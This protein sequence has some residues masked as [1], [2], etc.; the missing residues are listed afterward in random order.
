M[1]AYVKKHQ[2]TF[3]LVLL[4][5]VVCFGFMLTHH[6]I[7]IDEETWILSDSPSLL[8]L[9][10]GRF[11]TEIFNFFFTQQGRYA[12]FLW[13]F[14]S[15]VLWCFS[16]ILFSYSLVGNRKSCKE[17]PLFFFLA[18]FVS[19]PFVVGELLSFSM[20]NLQVCVAMVC[21]AFA[22]SDTLYYIE[23]PS[24]LRIVRILLLLIFSFSIYQCL[25][26]VYI[27][28]VVAF[29][30]LEFTE[31]RRML[32]RTVFISASFCM[33]SILLYYGG[34]TLLIH[35]VGADSYLSDNYVGWFSEGSIFKALFLAFAN[36]ARVSLAI[37]VLDVEI[38]GGL[39]IRI[40]TACFILYALWLFFQQKGIKDKALAFFYTLALV[41]A[42]FTLY[43][44]LGT[45]K[46]HGRILQALPLAG[47]VE[48]YI[49]LTLLKK[50]WFKKT[51]FV[52][53][54][55]LLFL[56]ARN[57]NMLFY[58]GSIAYEHDK[59]IAN[60]IMFEI[61]KAGFDYHEKPLV[62]L[63]S[64]PMDSI[65]IQT[66]ATIGASIFEWDDGN[67]KRM[68]DFLETEGYQ[69]IYPS[70][71]AVLEALSVMENMSPWPQ[72]GCLQET[73]NGIVIY[74]SEPSEKWYTVNNIER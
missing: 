6:T 36:I 2:K 66:S 4:F 19:M 74:L 16:G 61:Q 65:S 14:L 71:D 69:V 28:A 12:P 39:P 56:N 63:G 31:G 60:L 40:V 13:D 64:L 41:M 23:H 43:L 51:A 17:I 48:I 70:D 18:Y 15:I 57:M 53:L 29:C 68:T 9:F 24:A 26:N 30:L 55:Y 67:M 50:E 25:I 34:N 52:L 7:T 58:Y 21:V 1:A 11:G 32:G 8:W 22:F 54:A 35:L 33:L 44:V 46:T 3:I 62:F 45:Y 38:Y 42:P 5:A 27:T 72:E 49:I 10:Q 20:F 47:A 37:P 59:N 73:E